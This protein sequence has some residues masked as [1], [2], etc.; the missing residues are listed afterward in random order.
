MYKDRFEL[1]VKDYACVMYLSQ[2]LQITRFIF[3][4]GTDI[5]LARQLFLYLQSAVSEMN[6]AD[7]RDLC[8]QLLTGYSM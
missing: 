8:K 2:H 1:G 3:M 4:H 6:H 5:K 7:R